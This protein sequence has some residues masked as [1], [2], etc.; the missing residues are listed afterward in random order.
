[1]FYLNI[2]FSAFLSDGGVLNQ[3]EETEDS[4]QGEVGIW[5]DCQ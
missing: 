5:K 1:M 4:Q 3:T 2:F